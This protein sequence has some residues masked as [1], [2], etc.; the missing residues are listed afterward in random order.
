M[1][2]ALLMAFLGGLVWAAW[3]GRRRIED[4]GSIG[5]H[6]GLAGVFAVFLLQSGVDWIWES[7]AVTVLALVAAAIAAAAASERVGAPGERGGATASASVAVVLVALVAVVIQLPGLASEANLRA[8][9]E[10]AA[11]GD[12]ERAAAE[13]TDA[14]EAMPWA[15][16]GY[17]QR[18]LV[19]EAD[20]AYEAA[21][22]DLEAAVAREGS[23]WRWWLLLARVHAI[24]GEPVLA[25]SGYDR[26]HQLRPR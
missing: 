16:G 8:S 4:R 18:G 11:A 21:A 13:A 7:T 1:G 20:G 6:A 22:D 24:S 3:R 2:F 9:R 14:I 25:G 12:Y 10:A 17:G 5:V 19:L 15:A 26:A 23:N